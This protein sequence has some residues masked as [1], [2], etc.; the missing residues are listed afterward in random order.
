MINEPKEL[1][2]ARWTSFLLW[3]GATSCFFAPADSFSPSRPASH[4]YWPDSD[5]LVRFC[6]HCAKPTSGLAE[7]RCKPENEN[8][9]HSLPRLRTGWA[10]LMNMS[11]LRQ[12]GAA[13]SIGNRSMQTAEEPIVR[14]IRRAWA[15]LRKFE[16]NG[17]KFPGP[18]VESLKRA[19]AAHQQRF[20]TPR[21][22]HDF[23]DSL[24]LL[25][26]MMSHRYDKSLPRRETVEKGNQYAD[27][28][29]WTVI[30]G[31]AVA[32]RG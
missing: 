18:I 14:D 27:G 20:W 13:M 5:L 23:R 16:S 4:R 32:R 26:S 10:R 15:L 3:S 7:T 1:R 11:G 30:V 2:K 24:A 19:V 8:L 21:I 17:V 12:T 28:Q 22:D 9:L 6:K 25:E 31:K 29:G